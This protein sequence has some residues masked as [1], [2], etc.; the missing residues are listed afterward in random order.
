MS[1][2]LI[3]LGGDLARTARLDAQIVD[4]RVIAAD[5]GIRHAATLGVTPELWVG[6]FDS[7]PQ[8]LCER[9]ADV[10]RRSFSSDKD[11]TDGE[12]A[13]AA[14]LELGATS[15]VLAG[16]FGGPRADHAFLHLA[17]ALRLAEARTPTLLT[18]GT[19]EGSPVLP[20][21]TTFDYPDGTLFSILAFSELSGLTEE[22]AKW[23]LDRVEVPFGSSLTLSNEVRGT[24]RI[25][26][27]R[28][29]AILVAHPG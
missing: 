18:G 24:L 12:L 11:M 14:A 23:P 4:A 22:G 3:L 28:G 8:E 6:D 13:V 19:Q 26:L 21:T 15:L 9:Y 27:K 5:S 1:R 7:T 2:F 29:R 16:A 25:S 10:E 17:L 20:G